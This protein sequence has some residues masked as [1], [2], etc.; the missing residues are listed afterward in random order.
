MDK[1][2]QRDNQKKY[3]QTDSRVASLAWSSCQ[4]QR[5]ELFKAPPTFDLRNFLRPTEADVDFTISSDAT[6]NFSGFYVDVN[7]WFYQ[8]G[9]FFSHSANS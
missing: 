5:H 7:L 6:T 3:K 8:R 9:N 4:R 1:D 2:E